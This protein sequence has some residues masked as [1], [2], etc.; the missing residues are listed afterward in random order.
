[1]KN[2]LAH[3]FLPRESNNHRAKALHHSS[4]FVCLLLLFV[5]Q[6]SL[7]Y[8]HPSTH[9]AV[10]GTSTNITEEQLLKLTNQKRQDAGVGPLIRNALL[11]KVAA[12][13]ATDMFAKDYWAHNSPDGTTPWYFFRKVNY[14]YQYAGENLA[15][16]FTTA[17]DAMDAWMASPSHKENLLSP[18]YREI[19]FAVEDGKLTGEQT[20]L[21]VQEFGSTDAAPQPH[22]QK[23]PPSTVVKSGHALSAQ[24]GVIAFDPRIY[25]RQIIFIVLGTFLILFVIDMVIIERRKIVRFA[26]HTQDHALFLFILMLFVVLF[27]RG[28]IL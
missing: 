13:K 20:T 2:L 6:L 9:A 19:G 27:S 11:D 14:D 28:A 3:F 18:N 22:V 12:L 15:R 24:T 1:M 5:L 17:N 7:V 4:L 21:I 25:T 26:G 16:G 10:L 8:I 23:E